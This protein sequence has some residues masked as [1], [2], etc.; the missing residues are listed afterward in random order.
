[1]PLLVLWSCQLLLPMLALWSCQ[2]L[3]LTCLP[4]LKSQLTPLFLVFSTWCPF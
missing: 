3:F 4:L 2:L 1:M